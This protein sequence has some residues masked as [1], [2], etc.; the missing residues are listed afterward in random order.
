MSFVVKKATRQKLK[1][2]IGLQGPSGSG[3]TY[4]AL[5]LA[6]GIAGSWEK[7]FVVDSENDSATYYA[8]LGPFNHL[9]FYP[10]YTPE[11]YIEAIQTCMDEGAEVVV[12]DSV[13]H[14]WEGKGGCLDIHQHETD[15]QKY[16]NSFT[17]WA[18]VTPRHNKFVDF[19]RTSPVHILGCT[20]SKQDYVLEE[21]SKGK[22]VP[23][24]VGL[25]GVQR[26]GLDYEYGLMFTI[27]MDHM[28]FSEKDRTGLFAGEPKHQISEATGKRLVEW[29][30]AGAE[31]Y[32]EGKQNQ[33]L[34]LKKLLEEKEIRE[35]AAMKEVHEHLLKEKPLFYNLQDAVTK[36][37]E[38]VGL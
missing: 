9:S 25:K 15:V 3:K 4:S 28:A 29:A 30:N 5:K 22:S 37:V 34:E 8:D 13:S 17:A 6:H 21:N 16:G 2:K 26:D 7:V 36:Y 24:K 23:K 31:E 19:M 38:G 14:E 33:K 12:I 10:P 35:P 20:R 27:D 18:K 11:R 1:L 32:Y